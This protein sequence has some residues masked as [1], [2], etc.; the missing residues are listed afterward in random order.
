MIAYVTVFLERFQILRSVQMGHHCGAMN[1]E[2][3]ALK[4][5]EALTTLA[6]KS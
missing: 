1:A 5:Q 2:G 3:D 6:F 4:A